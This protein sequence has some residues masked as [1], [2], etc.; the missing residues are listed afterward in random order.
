M[1]KDFI[2]W[3]AVKA[4][5]HSKTKTV[6]YKE[7]EVWWFALGHNVG[8]EEDGKGTDF[9]RPVLIVRGFS[10]ALF[11]GLPLST[12]NKRGIYYYP[13]TNAKGT[14]SVALLSQLRAFDTK[15]LIVKQEMINATDFA[16]IKRSLID[17]LV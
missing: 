1:Q 16:A 11:W 5:I 7:R 4:A 13:F 2:A 12:T 10:S 17:F 9:T 8:C 3:H 14:T 15:R 6:G